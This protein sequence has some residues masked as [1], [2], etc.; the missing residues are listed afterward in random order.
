MLPTQ[1]LPIGDD[2]AISVR[3]LNKTYQTSFFGKSKGLVTAIS[4]LSLD[5]PKSG[6]FVLLGSNG[7]VF[8]SF[9]NRVYVIEHLNRAGKST[10]LS[11]IGGLSGRTSGTVAFQ[12]GVT[13]PPRGTIG[14]VP[15]KNVLFSELS[16]LQ[17]LRVWRAVKWSASSQADEDLEQMLRD[18]DLG[19]KIHSNAATLSGGQKRKLQLAIGLLGGSKSTFYVKFHSNIMLNL[20]TQSFLSMNV[21]LE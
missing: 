6:I 15:Q 9:M 11:V 16:C 1:A 19:A 5:I 20:C 2:I 18:C 3:N 10:S 13:R 12:G 7:F 17:T 21:P 14:I 4:D 8:L